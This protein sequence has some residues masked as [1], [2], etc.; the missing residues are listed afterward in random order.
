M[1]VDPPWAP[2]GMHRDLAVE[3]P[4]N[5]WARVWPW[6]APVMADPSPVAR[7]S[8]LKEG[9]VALLRGEWASIGDLLEDLSD[10]EW[11]LPALPG[12]DVHDV[13]A[14]LV[15]TERM[16]AG[17]STPEV[18]P[19]TTDLPHVRNDIA[20]MNEAWVVELRARTHA[21]LRDEFLTVT[22]ARL[23]AL[24][25]MDGADFESPSW[26]P[27]GPGTYGRFMEIRAFDCWMHEQDI[28]DVTGRPGNEEGPAAEQALD[29]VAR[30]LGY[31]V[32]KRVGA[33]DGSSVTIHLTG[34]LHRALH[35]AVDGRAA[36]VEA[37]PAAPTAEIALGSSL[38]LRLVGGRVPPEEALDRVI[39]GGDQ[40]LA[41]RLATEL[42]FTI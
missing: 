4:A 15:G 41:R 12:W 32:G 24:E 40:D 18:P 6:S 42:A 11:A 1:L 13:V 29:E 27:V 3:V 21:D 26:T 34:P 22:A 35:V 17:D 31:I 23:D 19:E 39:L 20:R 5:P 30:G 8:L 16:L 10:E 14:H 7:S 33:P 9:I 38:F 25:A 36:V 37:L 2:A 28:R